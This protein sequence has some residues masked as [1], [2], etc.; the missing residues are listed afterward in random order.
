MKKEKPLLVKVF[1][2][3]ETSTVHSCDPL[4]MFS[5][6]IWVSVLDIQSIVNT[7]LDCITQS[8]ASYVISVVK[9]EVIKELNSKYYDFHKIFSDGSK[10]GS[11][12]GAAY[13]DSHSA[14]GKSFMIRTEVS[15]MTAELIAISEALSYIKQN[16][17]KKCVIFS[18][19][20]S[21]LQHIVR[22]AVG[23]Y[24]GLPIAYEVLSK[25]FEFTA[26]GGQLCLQWVPSHIGVH[27]NETA[28]RLARAGVTQGEELTVL[29]DYSESLGKFRK[30]SFDN[31][32]AYFNEIS[33]EKG[34]WYKSLQGQPSYRPWFDGLQI[35]RRYIKLAMRLRSGHY[36]SNK[37]AFLM[38]KV[39]SP[40]C[41]LCKC[42]EDVQHLLMECVRSERQRESLTKK[43]KLNLYDIGIVQSILCRPAS[44]ACMELCNLVSL[45]H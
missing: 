6:E 34:I 17:W 5:L 28:D 42:I 27:G 29:P 20:K 44:D 1:T 19:S 40:N 14:Y 11:V 12:L 16:I 21:A 13:Y 18:D 26:C 31:W 9:F 41:D 7:N 10:S 36:P 3:T 15:I 33:V 39:P 35:S 8:K 22:C 24:R 37:F 45:R 38:G 25:I 43:L 32:I 23:R 30:Y 4:S 2:K